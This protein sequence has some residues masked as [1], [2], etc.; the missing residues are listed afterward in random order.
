M[1]SIIFVCGDNGSV[2]VRREDTYHIFLVK[3]LKQAYLFY[4]CKYLYVALESVNNQFSVFS[5]SEKAF[6]DSKLFT[7]IIVIIIINR[8]NLL[9]K[10]LLATYLHKYTQNQTS[11]R[12]CHFIFYT[13]YIKFQQSPAAQHS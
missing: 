3:S 7:I 2:E 8:K 12:I 11:N 6:P 9:S 10:Q 4:F 5:E 13:D 1:R